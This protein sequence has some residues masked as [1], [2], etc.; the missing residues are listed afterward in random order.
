[1]VLENGVIV[2]GE[3]SMIPVI[4]G[5]DQSYLFQAFVVMHSVLKNSRKKYHF[6]LL[7]KDDIDESA[8]KLENELKKRY[9]NFSLSIRKIERYMFTKAKI[10]NPHLA[11]AAYYR[12]LIPELIREYDKC[13]YLDCD[14]IVNGDLGELFDIDITDFYLAGVRDCHLISVETVPTTHQKRLGIPSVK[15]YINSGVLLMN[16]LKLRKENLVVAFLKQ[17]EKENLYE[18]QDVLNYCCYGAIKILPLKYNLFHFYCGHTIRYLFDL[19]YP[20]S[21][22][23]F[24][25]NTPFILHM[26]GKYKPCLNPVYKG[27]DV[28]WSLAKIFQNSESYHRYEKNCQ[29]N[30]DREI[31]EKLRRDGKKMPVIIWGFSIRGKG[32]CD[33]LMNK[34][35][36][37]YSFC[38]NNSIC[39][40]DSYHGILVRDYAEIVKRKYDF[41]WVVPCK[42]YYL[43]ICDQLAEYGISQSNIVC[44]TY[45]TYLYDKSYYRALSPKFYEDELKVI[46]AYECNRKGMSMEAYFSYLCEQ[47]KTADIADA[48]Y[49]YIYKKYRFDQ[50]LKSG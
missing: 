47:I 44:F 31:R 23:M 5:L 45:E 37:V 25:W 6:F 18:D 49:R 16:L 28:W 17:S 8:K 14:V 7:T 22:F 21:D 1:M 11:Q 48:E 13:I 42:R 2:G 50:W 15:D 29:I 34:G 43:E 40:G 26:G 19:P 20:G 27:A 41:I 36:P 24:D 10:F 32:A 39:W 33:I 9:S 4:F 3:M 12:L 35:I 38:D 30:I 46:A